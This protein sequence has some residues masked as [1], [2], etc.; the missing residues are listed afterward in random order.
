M[1]ARFDKKFAKQLGK[2]PQKIRAIFESH[3]VLFLE[4]MFNPLL[5]NHALLGQ[6]KS[7][8]TINIT[9]DIRAVYK[10]IDADTVLFVGFGT[11]SQLY[12]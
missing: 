10:M 8:R 1:K 7:C 11:H 6:Y 2:Y 3:L 4:D 12:T 9:G 5:N